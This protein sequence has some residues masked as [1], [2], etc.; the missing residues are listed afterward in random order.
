MKKHIPNF[1][2]GLNAVSGCIAVYM[3]FNGL[4]LHASVFICIGALLDFCDGMSARLLNAY[5]DIGKELDSLS[6]MISFGFA[7]AAIAYS[8]LSDVYE[9]EL[10][11][12]VNGDMSAL[13]LL[14]PFIMVMFSGLRLAKF[15]IDT[16]Q[17]SS[18]IG[19]P[20]PANAILWASFPFILKYGDVSWIKDMINNGYFIMTLSLGM[21]YMLV[22]EIPMFS[23]KMKSL[24]LKDNYT[25]YIFLIS[26]VLLVSLVGISFMAFIIPM[27]IMFSIAE[28]IIYK[29]IA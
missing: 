22:A 1:I 16:R 12:L 6:D 2:T 27:Y 14:I 19:V 29:K 8:L 21:S 10:T 11:D 23:F 17:T 7:P 13:Y 15:N 5:S 24:K 26:T 25:R 20:T 18:F 3:A 9:L 28:N 4:L